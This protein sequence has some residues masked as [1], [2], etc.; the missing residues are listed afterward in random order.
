MNLTAAGRLNCQSTRRRL[1]CPPTA[2]PLNCACKRRL[3]TIALWKIVTPFCRFMSGDPGLVTVDEQGKVIAVR[4]GATHIVVEYL[5]GFATV[6]TTVPFEG[7]G[8]V[9]EAEPRTSNVIDVLVQDK[10]RQLNLT[11]SPSADD[12]AFLRRVTLDVVGRLPTL[13]EI[14][15]FTAS[16]HANRREEL[17]ER[18]LQEDRHAA[19]WA[20]RFCDITRS[21]ADLME[22][23]DELKS[24]RAKMWHDWFRVRVQRNEPYDEIV[25]G[26]LCGT[27]IGEQSVDEWIDSEA[28][29]IRAA[30]NGFET[31]YA[32]RIPAICSGGASAATA[33]I[34]LGNWPR[35]PQPRSSACES[36]ALNATSIPMIAGRKPTTGRT[37]T[38]SPACSSAAPRS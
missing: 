10:L 22:G 26:W 14:R 17:I 36:S 13:D 37:S 35:L 15:D 31:D 7:E 20:T 21:T 34:Q 29:L 5:G 16:D 12:Y 32:A 19:L 33:C 6:T 28:G 38:F 30:K 8:P 1:F 24:K 25:R 23:P 11:I 9:D 18:L 4:S 2:R 3:A 27:S